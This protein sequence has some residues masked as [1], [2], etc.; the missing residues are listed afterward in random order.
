[1]AS[2]PISDEELAVLRAEIDRARSEGLRG[3]SL[4]ISFLGRLVEE[5]ESLRNRNHSPESELVKHPADDDELVTRD[6][7]NSL[8]RLWI[9]KHRCAVVW[10]Y[11]RVCFRIEDSVKPQPQLKTRGDVRSLFRALGKPLKET[12]E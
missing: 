3:Y 8:G 4:T 1:M 11:G 5:F 7:L 10:K 2:E 9:W 6:W 12:T